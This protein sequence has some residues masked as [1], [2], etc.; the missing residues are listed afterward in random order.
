MVYIK[1]D[2]EGRLTAVAGHGF[3][4]GEGE[5]A[6]DLPDDFAPPARD[7]V[8]KDGVLVHDPLP[9]EEPP[10]DQLEV[11][12]QEN[13]LLKAQ[14]QALTDRGEFIEDCI[15]EMATVVYGG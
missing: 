4:C 3:H 11:L 1:V 12:Q 10:V 13:T 5:I 15:A 8:L 6:I 14:V 9:E 7:W 2:D